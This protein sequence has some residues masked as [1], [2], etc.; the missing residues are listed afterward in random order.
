MYIGLCHRVYVVSIL[1]C[2]DRCSYFSVFILVQNMSID[3]QIERERER[4][5]EVGRER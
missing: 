4:E 3:A 2:I 5:R 1:A